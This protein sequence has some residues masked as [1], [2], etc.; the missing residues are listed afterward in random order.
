M[1]SQSRRRATKNLTRRERR[2]GIARTYTVPAHAA[3]PSVRRS[4][5][6]EPAPVDYSAE[7]RY[8]RKDLFRIL[9]WATVLIVG[10]IVLSFM[11]IL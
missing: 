5:M 7:Y 11:P 2:S 10:M 8:I 9:L 6:A 1:A 3:A 4:Y